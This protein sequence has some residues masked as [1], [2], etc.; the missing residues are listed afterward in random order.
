MH[1]PANV[2]QSHPCVWNVLSKTYTWISGHKLLTHN[3]GGD[4]VRRRTT[5]TPQHRQLYIGMGLSH[6]VVACGGVVKARQQRQGNMH[7]CTRGILLFTRVLGS[8]SIS[9]CKAQDNTGTS[10]TTPEGG[11]FSARA[12]KYLLS[13]LCGYG[14]RARVALCLTFTLSLTTN[15]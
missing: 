15:M 5:L 9:I 12:R 4:G 2:D 14:V 7:A 13:H 1:L 10:P 3:L 6:K 8:P 11:G